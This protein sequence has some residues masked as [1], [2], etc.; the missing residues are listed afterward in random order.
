LGSYFLV[1]FLPCLRFLSFIRELMGRGITLG[2]QQ[3]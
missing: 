1:Y 2:V 3:K